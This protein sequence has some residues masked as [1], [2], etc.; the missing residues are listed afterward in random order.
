MIGQ[1]ISL[2][3]CFTI[4]GRPF[5]IRSA[6]SLDPVHS[7]G[8]KGLQAMVPRVP[9][10]RIG[11]PADIADVVVFLLSDKARYI[12]GQVLTVDGGMTVAL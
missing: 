1:P 8:A 11:D 3:S 9:L 10:G 7:V 2:P 4:R 12:T 6:Q 5:I